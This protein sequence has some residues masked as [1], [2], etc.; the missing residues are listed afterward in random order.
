MGFYDCPYADATVQI[1]AD[2]LW[3]RM[4]DRYKPR[5]ISDPDAAVLMDWIT[6]WGVRQGL[7]ADMHL[8][9]SPDWLRDNASLDNRWFHWIVESYLSEL[10]DKLHT[11]GWRTLDIP[12]LYLLTE[13]IAL[14][15][16]DRR[17]VVTPED[18][19]GVSSFVFNV[20]RPDTYHPPDIS[21][22]GRRQFENLCELGGLLS[23]PTGPMFFL[24]H[25][26]THRSWMLYPL[27]DT[28]LPPNAGMVL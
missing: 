21:W 9:C 3:R 7:T 26:D 25:T 18:L 2:E 13:H 4:S 11:A 6:E 22:P 5:L 14:S 24:Y 15:L 10:Q 27:L 8:L 17:C 16:A 12:A 28:I 19:L 20:D 1:V 23:N